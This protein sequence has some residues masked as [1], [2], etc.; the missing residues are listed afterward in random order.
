MSVPVIN[1]DL[2]TYLAARIPGLLADENFTAATP[3]QGY[4]FVLREI[5]ADVAFNFDAP[6]TAGMLIGTIAPEV[7]FHDYILKNFR[8]ELNGSSNSSPG[9]EADLVSYLTVR[10]PDIESQSGFI[11]SDGGSAGENSFKYMLR[12][13]LSDIA[14]NIPIADVGTLFAAIIEREEYKTEYV[15]KLFK[16]ILEIRSKT[17]VLFQLGEANSLQGGFT[18]VNGIAAV[19][20]GR[21]TFNGWD[22]ADGSHQSLVVADWVGRVFRGFGG[23]SIRVSAAPI[24]DGA[25]GSVPDT[26]SSTFGIFLDLNRTSEIEADFGYPRP[27]YLESE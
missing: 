1:T 26:N 14:T 6:T 3:V 21:A 7:F 23:E 9:V 18:Y 4:K 19:S 20:G 24:N 27:F 13:V 22:G 5:L 11:D 16:N 17:G 25:P 2:Q 12:L 10:V 15:F 8:D